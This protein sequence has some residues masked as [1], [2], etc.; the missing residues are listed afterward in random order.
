MTFANLPGGKLIFDRS[1]QP[2]SV[3]VI[4]SDDNGTTWHFVRSITSELDGAL[5]N[6]SSFAA[7]GDGFIIAARAP[8]LRV[9]AN[10]NRQGFQ[11]ATTHRLAGAYPFI[12]SSLGRPR[13]IVRDG[14]CYLLARNTL[15]VDS[16]KLSE[17]KGNPM[18][19]SW[20]KVDLTS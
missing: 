20:F 9:V 5:I 15:E 19:L 6:E 1:S 14:G 18:R 3:D 10:A 2:G 16:T 8:P 11:S 13:V 12:Q 17:V 4:R 7:Y